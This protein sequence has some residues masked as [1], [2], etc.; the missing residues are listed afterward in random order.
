MSKEITINFS[1]YSLFLIK[2]VLPGAISGV[3]E[4]ITTHPLDRI[5]TK[6]Q[7]LMLELNKNNRNSLK[8][9][10]LNATKVIYKESGFKGFYLGIIPRIGGV[11]PMRM[12]YWTTMTQMNNIVESKNFNCRFNTNDY[13]IVDKYIKYV[14]PGLVAGSIQTIIDNPIEVAKIRLMT[15]KNN[16][17]SK[18]SELKLYS[19]EG[20]KSMYVGF[21]PTVIR[22]SIF[23]VF[24]SSFVKIYGEK[25]ENK[26]ISAAIGGALGS[27]FSQPFDVIKTE[28]QRIKKITDNSNNSNKKIGTFELMLKIAKNNPSQLWAG[29]SMR[30]IQAFFNM[31]IG[32][33]ALSHIQNFINFFI[34]F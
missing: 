32:F 21:I 2:N 15:K 20:I 25:K 8:P 14:F 13:M 26:F 17:D 24:V 16:T 3:V 33:L 30:C 19:K 6:M 11:I 34:D 9:S 10:F 7:E 29:G 27:I 1:D 28:F 4:V 22:N 31:G 5:K 18:L 12:T 23:A